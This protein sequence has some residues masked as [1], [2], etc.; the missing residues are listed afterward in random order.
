MTEVK[1]GPH[2]QQAYCQLERAG[3][4]R[5]LDVIDDALDILETDPGDKQARRRSFGDGRWGIPVRD[6]DDD[7]LIIWSPAQ[8]R[9]KLPMGIACTESSRWRT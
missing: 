8:S 2:A 5:L 9:R 4:L 3:A 7:L 6:A 1:L